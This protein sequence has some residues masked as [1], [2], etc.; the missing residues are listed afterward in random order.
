MNCATR[1]SGRSLQVEFDAPGFQRRS[2]LFVL[3]RILAWFRAEYRV[4]RDMRMLREMDDRFL[5]D[6]G[7]TRGEVLRGVRSTPASDEKR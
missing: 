6:I 7:L 4:R 5:S 3:G 1:E 2:P